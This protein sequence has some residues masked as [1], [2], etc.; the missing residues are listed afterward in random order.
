MTLAVGPLKAL[1]SSEVDAIVE[2]LLVQCKPA[3]MTLEDV[4]QAVLGAGRR[5]QVLL[6]EKLIE[7]AE[8]ETSKVRA[9]CAQC[10][11]KMRHRGYRDKP[12]VTQAGEVKVRRS[13]Y[14]CAKCGRGLFPPR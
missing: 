4:E 8:S 5:F 6:T 11:E 10:G 7:A 2:K 14:R 1:M 12:L 13:Y 9:Q 3:E